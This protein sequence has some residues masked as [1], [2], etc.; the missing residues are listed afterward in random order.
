MRAWK[1]EKPSPLANEPT[2]DEYVQMK[3]A[4]AWRLT[5]KLWRMQ[6]ADDQARMITHEIIE[7]TRSNFETDQ[8]M[9][10]GGKN[11]SNDESQLAAMKRRMG[12]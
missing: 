9:A 7:N 4:K 10:G 12:M 6:S 5:P 11:A 1:P 8:R 3:T 2:D